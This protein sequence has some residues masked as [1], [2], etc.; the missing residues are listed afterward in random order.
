MGNLIFIVAIIAVMYFFMIRPQRQQQKKMEEERNNM[1]VGDNV[2]TNGGI[3]GKIDGINTT[4]DQ[5]GNTVV[6]SFTLKLK[7]EYQTRIVVSKDCVFK[8]LNDAK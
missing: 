5:K 3:F 8:D 1:K 2:V 6:T 7:P 4:T